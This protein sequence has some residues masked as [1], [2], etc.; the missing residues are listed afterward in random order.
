MR[1]FNRLLATL[2]AGALA[3]FSAIV[4][5][6]II[7]GYY[8]GRDP[9]LLPWDRW[10]HRSQ[11]LTWSDRSVVVTFV[12]IG[13]AGILLLAAQLWRRKPLALP[14]QDTTPDVHAE[15]NRRSLEHVLTRAALSIDGVS[16]AHVRSRRRRVTVH[17]ATQRRQPGDLRERVNAKAAEVLFGL[18][19]Q[20]PPQLSVDVDSRRKV[21]GEV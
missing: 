20:K 2:L 10:Y 3:V 12:L 19:L 15:I 7:L 6:E 13:L 8:F 1:L 16:D 9:W 18:R 11:E 5:V 21:R 14:L 4:A 17:A